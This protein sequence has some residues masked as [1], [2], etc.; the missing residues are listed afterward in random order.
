MI[1]KIVRAVNTLYLNNIVHN[2]VIS[3]ALFISNYNDCSMNLKR[4]IL[5]AAKIYMN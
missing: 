4:N 3:M 1:V 5:D 2:E